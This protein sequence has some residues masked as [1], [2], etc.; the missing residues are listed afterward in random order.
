MVLQAMNQVRL[1][2]YLLSWIMNLSVIHRE[3]GSYV[4]KLMQEVVG[5][6]CLTSFVSISVA[7]TE[8]CG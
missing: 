2:S 3:V 5:N 6:F 4:H 1:Q 8:L 7:T